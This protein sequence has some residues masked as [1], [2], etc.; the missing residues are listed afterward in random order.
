MRLVTFM[1]VVLLIFATGCDVV[2]DVLTPVEDNPWVGEWEIV[3]IDS[4]SL[5]AMFTDQFADFSNISFLNDGT[6]Y[7]HVES[8]FAE[9]GICA[10]FYL[11]FWGTYTLKDAQFTLTVTAAVGIFSKDTGTWNLQNKTLTLTLDNGSI[12]VLERIP[13]PTTLAIPSDSL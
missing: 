5:D 10:G 3:T 4:V 13:T 11:E 7:G 2:Q 1:F 6:W 8:S 9:S 12:I